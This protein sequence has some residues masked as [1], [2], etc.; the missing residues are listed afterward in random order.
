[1]RRLEQPVSLI[2]KIMMRLKSKITGIDKV[3][4]GSVTYADFVSISI[5]I[6]QCGH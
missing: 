3:Q 5:T 1:M 2:H 6:P 4:Y